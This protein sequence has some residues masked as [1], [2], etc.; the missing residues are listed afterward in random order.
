M[1]TKNS[2][3]QSIVISPVGEIDGLAA[4]QWRQTLRPLVEE[5]YRFILFD[6]EHTDYITSSGLG[7]LVEIYNSVTRQEGSLRVVN[8][9]ERVL[10][11]LR[12]SRLDSILMQEGPIAPD[13]PVEDEI[14]FDALHDLMSRE[15]LFCSRLN[16]VAELSLKSS[17]RFAIARHILEGSRAA[18][19]AGRGAMYF[20]D[21][22][23]GELR[24]AAASGGDF[25]GGAKDPIPLAAG[26]PD[27]RL[28]ED[29][30][31]AYLSERIPTIG[32]LSQCLREQLGFER[33][34]LVPIRGSEDLL[35]LMALEQHEDQD[36]P[37]EGF[38]PLL[39]TYASICGLAL[40]KAGL[41]DRLRVQNEDL[42]HS[43]LSI[44]K[45][46][47]TIVDVGRLAALGAVISGLGHLLNNKLV[48]IIGYTQLLGQTADLS[49]KSRSQLDVVNT[50]AVELKDIMEKLVQ[51]SGVREISAARVDINELISRTLT[52]L[53]YHVQ[54]NGVALVLDLDG[55]LPGVMGDQDLL[56]QAF[57]AIVHRACTSFPSDREDRRVAIT[58]RK[59]G[60]S[61]E[62]TFEDNGSGL[63]DV[64]DAD[65]LDPLVPYTELADGKLFNY[66]IP[67]SVVKRHRGSIELGQGEE[68]GALV[69]ISLPLAS[70]EPGRE[71][72]AVE[73]E[74][75]SAA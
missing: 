35:G 48:P 25:P 75:A 58:T 14:V 31:I 53:G 22:A 11:L 26:D 44:Q 69:T 20:Y 59:A 72:L 63:G 57:I 2:A 21:R 36:E 51:V 19:G 64:A 65:W 5:G 49:E 27:Y 8:P 16:E 32:A 61:V 18:S 68:G 46:Q 4:E 74:G 73:S 50:A 28:F 52:L 30:Q 42:N 56:L 70:P 39:H 60:S 67:R 55:E 15:L 66:S 12:Q 47:D 62:I 41:L 6:L 54:R 3:S 23:R 45:F 7:M 34:A 71:A 40:E 29:K 33:F 37:L 1:I 24:L 9:G 10:W 17:D 13:A 38:A 43:L